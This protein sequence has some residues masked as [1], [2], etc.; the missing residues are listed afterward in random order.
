LEPP[1]QNT[2]DGIARVSEVVH[3]QSTGCETTIISSQ[4]ADIT[5]RNL[6]WYNNTFS[7]FPDRLAIF[8]A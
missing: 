2:K 1:T 4:Q 5:V 8:S 7:S 6:G 3:F